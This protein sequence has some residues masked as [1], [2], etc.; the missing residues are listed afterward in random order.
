MLLLRFLL[1]RG[2]F[3]IFFLIFFFSLL[4]NVLLI[5][6][7]FLHFRKVSKYELPLNEACL[8]LIVILHSCFYFLSHLQVSSFKKKRKK[9]GCEVH[10]YNYYYFH[11]SVTIYAA[12]DWVVC[13]NVRR[14]AFRKKILSGFSFLNFII[15][16][17]W[18][19]AHGP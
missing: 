2:C 18:S 13:S 15:F 1:F 3:Y 7:S 12:T 4:V 17:G 11:N 9:I 10:F 16:S 14:V 19:H 6:N 8:D 5:A